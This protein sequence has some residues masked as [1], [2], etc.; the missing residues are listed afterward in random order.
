MK[1]LYKQRSNTVFIINQKKI[2]INDVNQFLHNFDS[3][4]SSKDFRTW[5]S[6]NICCNLLLKIIIFGNIKSRKKLFNTI[7]KEVATQLH[8]TESVCKKKYLDMNLYNLYLENP[9]EFYKFSKKKK[10]N[11]L[12]YGENL[13]MNYLNSIC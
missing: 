13:F 8:H 7:V 4:I 10:Y 2:G 12:S 1:K 9:K 6:N 5:N 3:H 11:Y